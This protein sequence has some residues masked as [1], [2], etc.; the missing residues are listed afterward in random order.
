MANVYTVRVELTG[1]VGA[2]GINTWRFSSG[3]ID[4]LTSLS[5]IGEAFLTDIR[6]VYD[7]LRLYVVEGWQANPLPVVTRHDEVTGE[8]QETAGMTLTGWPVTGLG[9]AAGSHESRATQLVASYTTDQIRNGR[10]LRGRSF[11]GPVSSVAIDEDGQIPS[12]V[13][14]DLLGAFGAVTSGLGP[15]L[16]VWGQPGLMAGAGKYGD[17]Q[18]VLISGRPGS[19]RSRRD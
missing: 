5:N 13:R 3:G 16:G 12:S 18:E 6:A 15:R 7:A 1:W 2:P 8:L 17:V 19:L 11:L 4:P 9:D 14:T 10:V